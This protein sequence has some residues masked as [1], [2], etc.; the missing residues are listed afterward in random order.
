MTL[1]TLFFPQPVSPI[2]KLA[3]ASYPHPSEGRKDENH[4]H[5]KLTKMIT[6][7]IAL[8]HSLKLWAVLCRAAQEG[9][10]M[11][12]SSNKTWFT[13]EGNDIVRVHS[14]A[15]R[16]PWT[17]W[18]DEKIWHWKMNPTPRLAGVQYA[19]GELQRNSFKRNGYGKKK[20]KFNMNLEC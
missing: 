13:G 9:Q 18:K 5:R 1:S 16:T 19:T 7:I 3:Q 12:E 10:V 14:S 15:L 8:C 2:R 6:W 20:K 17:V 11:V 4:N